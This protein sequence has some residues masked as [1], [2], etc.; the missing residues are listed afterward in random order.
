MG[1]LRTARELGPREASIGS[2]PLRSVVWERLHG[3][4]RL[5]PLTDVDLASFDSSDSCRER[6]H[7]VE[8]PLIA[9]S[10]A[11]PRDAIP[12]WGSLWFARTIW[13]V[14]QH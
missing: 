9:A 12:G 4:A 14:E 3:N 7:D 8:D 11:V 10:P 6:E 5:T 2:G 13:L 1:A